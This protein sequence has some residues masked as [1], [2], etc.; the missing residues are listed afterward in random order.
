[1]KRNLMIFL[2]LLLVSSTFGVD[3][4]NFNQ[5]KASYEGEV[6]AGTFVRARVLFC[7]DTPIMGSAAGPSLFVAQIIGYATCPSGNKLDMD[8]NVVVG[9]GVGDPVSDRVYVTFDKLTYYFN[10]T[11]Q[12]Q[13]IIAS[14]AV[15]GKIGIPAMKVISKEAENILKAA[16]AS[17]AE[18]AAL[19]LQKSTELSLA[20]SQTLN[21]GTMMNQAGSSSFTKLADYFMSLQSQALPELVTS[22]A[23]EIE[24]VVRDSFP[25]YSKDFINN[26]SK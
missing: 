14:A 12:K 3:K 19:A 5:K 25:Y 13:T 10:G 9:L 26:E 11:Q 24:V 18:T 16:A 20:N 8:K 22:N 23:T 21:G 17:A 15:N 4:K 2:I 6:L 1:M 7:Q